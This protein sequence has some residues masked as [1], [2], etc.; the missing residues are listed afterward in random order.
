M[1]A[2]C[3]GCRH[4]SPVRYDG[5][6]WCSR[7]GAAMPARIVFQNGTPFQERDDFLVEIS[8]DKCRNG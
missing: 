1:S 4:A 8:L 2:T 6:F 7:R 5:S 3:A